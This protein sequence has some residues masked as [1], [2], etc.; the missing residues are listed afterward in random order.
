[1]NFSLIKSK[2]KQISN[3]ISLLY[4][5]ANLFYKLDKKSMTRRNNELVVNHYNDIKKVGAFVII[6]AVPVLS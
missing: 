4:N 3:G 6:Q 1:M 5:E 2:F